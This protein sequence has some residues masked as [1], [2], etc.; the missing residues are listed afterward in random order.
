MVLCLTTWLPLFTLSLIFCMATYRHTAIRWTYWYY[1]TSTLWTQG[2]HALGPGWRRWRSSSE[3]Y[4]SPDIDDADEDWGQST[5][6]LGGEILVE[7]F[8]IFLFLHFC[9]HTFTL[10]FNFTAFLLHL[11]CGYDFVS[12]ERGFTGNKAFWAFP[13]LKHLLF[14]FEQLIICSTYIS[15]HFSFLQDIITRFKR[16]LDILCRQNIHDL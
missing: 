10:T 11:C 2:N 1:F 13:L 14:C 5:F 6:Q 16:W 3:F 9:T 4:P 7:F 8:K 12:H 15:L